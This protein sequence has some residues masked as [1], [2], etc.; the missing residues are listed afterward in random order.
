MKLNNR[1]VIIIVFFTGAFV[2]YISL[3][4]P[5][6]DVKLELDIPNLLL[7]IIT[8]FV[9]LYIADTL[10][11]RVNRDQN[12]YSY[13]INKIDAVWA[14]FN[15]LS[16]KMVYSDN[17]DISDVK[18][19]NTDIIHPLIFLEQVFKSFEV[20]KECI[21]DLISK[22]D[23]LESFLSELPSQNNVVSIEECKEQ[24]EVKIIGL[25]LCFSNVLKV[26]QND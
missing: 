1:W 9:G 23:E 18:M 22:L 25:N 24:L 26:I 17:L 6:F 16:E 7:S 12:Q 8:L 4:V 2:C 20:N 19:V 15:N 5:L 21:C 13:I 11:K 14:V 3:Q 10:Q